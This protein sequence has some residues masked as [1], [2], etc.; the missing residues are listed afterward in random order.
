MPTWSIFWGCNP[1]HAHPRHLSRYSIFPRGFFTGKGH[2]GR[3]MIVVDPR[4]TDT[5]KM[6]DIG[7]QLEQGRD[8]ELLSAI[9][10]AIRGERP[11]RR[12]GRHPAR[13]GST[14]R[15]R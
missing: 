14:R 11:A 2:K 9:R 10:V 5:M 15:S 12:R 4:N 8:Y 1:A 7:L 3:K 13:S 6:A